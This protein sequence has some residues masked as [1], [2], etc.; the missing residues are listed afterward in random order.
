MRWEMRSLRRGGVWRK[1]W[2]T[3]FR[4]QVLPLLK[5]PDPTLQ[6]C[7]HVRSIGEG[8]NDG[9]L[10]PAVRGGTGAGF[11]GGGDGAIFSVS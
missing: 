9:A 7:G 1:Y 2:S 4:K 11:V 3:L 6:V 8:C 10:A 5:T